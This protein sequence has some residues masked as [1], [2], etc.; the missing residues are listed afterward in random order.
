[1]EYDGY[2]NTELFLAWVEH[3]LCKALKPEQVVIMDNASFHKSNKVKELIEKVGG[4]LIYLP[5]YSPDLNPIEHVWANLKRLLRKH[6]KRE[7]SLSKAIKD[8]LVSLNV[9]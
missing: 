4:K 2:T 6:P 8:S 7:A 1:M 5:S 3:C 9:G